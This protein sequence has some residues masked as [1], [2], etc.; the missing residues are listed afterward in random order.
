MKSKLGLVFPVFL[1]LFGVYALITVFNT[2]GEQVALIDGQAIPRGLATMFGLLCFGGGAFVIFSVL[3]RK[4]SQT[5][6]E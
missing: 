1:L 2:N 5:V 6:A 4:S 3:S